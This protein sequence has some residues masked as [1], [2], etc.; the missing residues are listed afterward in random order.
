MSYERNRIN[1]FGREFDKFSSYW[2]NWY[3]GNHPKKEY[4]IQFNTKLRM[5]LGIKE[6][7]LEP[8]FLSPKERDMKEL[9]KFLYKLTDLWFAYETFF[10]FY[11]KITGNNINSPT[12]WLEQSTHIGYK[13]DIV[14]NALNKVNQEVNRQF[15]SETSRNRLKKYI[16]HCENYAKNSQKNRL[17]QISSNFGAN[18]L[19][20]DILTI[21]Y[22]IRNNYVHNG[23]TTITNAGLDMLDFSF[24]ETQKLKIVKICY[25]FLAI[26]TVNIANKLI[27]QHN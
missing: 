14:S 6:I 22:A 24:N 1:D 3:Y 23:E 18:L 4:L 17:S 11:K 26:L 15:S 13:T 9:H 7:E 27:E 19:I 16:Q 10:K 8:D 21:T 20:K 2:D 5:P 25:D 12:V